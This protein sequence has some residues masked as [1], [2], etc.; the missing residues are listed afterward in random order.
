MGYEGK[1]IADL[2]LLH[3]PAYFDFRKEDRVYFPFM[4][5]SGDV[6]ITPMYEYFP[7]GFKTIKKYLEDR[8]Y[9]VRI[10]NLCSLMLIYPETDVDALLKNIEAKAVGIDLHWMVHIQGSLGIAKR[11]KQVNPDIPVFFGGISST[12]FADELI[13]YPFIDMVM[14]GYETH[15]PMERLMEQLHGSRDYSRVPNL[16]W[17]DSGGTIRDNR[18]SYTPAEYALGIDWS[19]IPGGDHHVLSISEILSTQNAGCRY[20]C[21]WCG[22]S[23]SAFRR[24]YGCS[25]SVSYKSTAQIKKEFAS[26]TR[27]SEVGSFS[28]YACGSYNETPERF[29]VLLR[30]VKTCGFKSVNYEQFTLTDTETLKKMVSAN[31]RT[32]LTLSPESHDRRISRLAGRGAYS[33]EEM[34]QW[35]DKALSIGI[36]QVDIWFFVGMPE[37]TAQSV[38]DMVDYCGKLLRRFEGRRV[39][40]YIC[41]M[42]PFLDPGSNFFTAPEKYGYTVHYR[43]AEEHRRAMGM[44]SV[45]NRMNYSTKWMDRQTIVRS[46]Y[47]AIIRLNEIKSGFGVLPSGIAGSANQKLRDAL[48]FL[49]E[50]HSAD[51]IPDPVQRDA[52]LGALSGE[53]SRRNKEVLFSGVSNQ[54]FPL[55]RKIGSRWIDVF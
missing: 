35:I 29:D 39:F 23:S 44:A 2:V 33:M 38:S 20:N 51:S 42:M 54:A 52:A 47:N 49:H 31:S 1:I 13:R 11:L 9:R 16:I 46:G 25:H 24:L 5:T 4:S 34:E 18:L 8:G 14:R 26:I 6:P 53:I 10:I 43:S 41:P 45:I 50:V 37:Q 30:A 17:K 32:V 40:P 12:Y 55:N 36:Y 48:G 15:M 27:I 22:G 21:G 19:D 28:Y 3:A 7:L